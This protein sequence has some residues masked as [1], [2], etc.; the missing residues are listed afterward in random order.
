MAGIGPPPTPT[1]ILKARGS[2]LPR[3]RKKEPQLGKGVPQCP[4]WLDADAKKAWKDLVPV[5]DGMGVLTK[6]EKRALARYCDLSVEYERLAIFVAEHG[7]TYPIK[8]ADGAVQ[9]LCQFPQAVRKMALADVLLR[10][11]QQFGL[12]P[13]ARTRI[14]VDKKETAVDGIERFFA[15]G[16][17]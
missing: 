16:V 8:N 12:T 5:L 6:A 11:E 15:K 7:S 1:A 3:T 2:W 14:Q 13:S 17:G 9:R 10:L 4:S